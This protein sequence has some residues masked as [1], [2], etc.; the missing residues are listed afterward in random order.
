MITCTIRR[1]NGHT[2]YPPHS[3]YSDTGLT[4]DCR[5]CSDRESL[6]PY[7]CTPTLL[8]LIFIR[9][10]VI[11]VDINVFITHLT[12]RDGI[13]S[14]GALFTNRAGVVGGPSNKRSADTFTSLNVI[15]II[16]TFIAIIDA[17]LASSKCAIIAYSVIF[18]AHYEL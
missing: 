10:I 15:F 17:L 1:Y 11:I 2:S 6:P 13:V 3:P 16:I 8:E 12:A 14:E 4:Q 7:S 18:I 5:T 9:N